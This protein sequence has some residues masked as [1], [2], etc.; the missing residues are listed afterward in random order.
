MATRVSRVLLATTLATIASAGMSTL[1]VGPSPTRSGTVVATPDLICGTPAP[2]PRPE[3]T[4][5]PAP[6]PGSSPHPGSGT[7]RRPGS[8]PGGRDRDGVLTV[9]LH[10][11][12]L[13]AAGQHIRGTA[14]CLWRGRPG[15]PG[16]GGRGARVFR[17]AE[18]H[19]RRPLRV[20]SAQPGSDQ[21]VL[22]R[23]QRL[24]QQRRD[25]RPG[26]RRL[27]HATGRGPVRV[28]RRGS[29][30]NETVSPSPI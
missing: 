20:Q 26:T 23:R 2:P 9:R 15:R 14:R 16:D 30:G 22:V 12:P 3:P 7:G 13:H 21:P 29:P 27:P 18:G 10:P 24:P 8:G 1:A 19:E 28:P 5:S 4:P 25:L 6:D 17:A 11:D